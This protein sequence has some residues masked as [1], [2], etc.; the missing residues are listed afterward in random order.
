MACIQSG[1]SPTPSN[2][3]PVATV[4]QNDDNIITLQIK[5]CCWEEVD[6]K[7]LKSNRIDCLGESSNDSDMEYTMVEERAC[8]EMRG[9]DVP[10]PIGLDKMNRLKSEVLVVSRA[11]GDRILEQSEIATMA[12]LK[13]FEAPD[14]FSEVHVLTIYEDGDCDLEVGE[15]FGN[16]GVTTIE[17]GTPIVETTIGIDVGT[18]ECR[19]AVWRD[20]KVE[21][22][23]N[24]GGQSM[25][26]SY[27]LFQGDTPSIGVSSDVSC[28]ISLRKCSLE[29]R[30]LMWKG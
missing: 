3:G 7:C 9:R 19:V 12:E 27:V 1:S 24:P 30:S 29:V 17:G 8:Q 4:T 14:S 22:L 28:S 13:G 15:N 10:K 2:P 5:N 21:L 16:G 25:M 6:S 26:P 11:F 20:S 23:Q 18:C